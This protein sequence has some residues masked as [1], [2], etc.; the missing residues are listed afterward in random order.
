MISQ[1]TVAK[2]YPDSSIVLNILAAAYSSVGDFAGS[3]QKYNKAISLTPNNPMLYN[4][5]AVCYRKQSKYDYARDGFDEKLDM[6]PQ[7]FIHCSKMAR[8]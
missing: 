1:K 8:D 2:A 6:S 4:N 5:L 3:E 7:H